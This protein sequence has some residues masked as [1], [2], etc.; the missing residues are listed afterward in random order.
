MNE[1]RQTIARRDAGAPVLAEGEEEVL[2]LAPAASGSAALGPLAMVLALLLAVTA[3]VAGI[4]SYLR[5]M[6]RRRRERRESTA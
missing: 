5:A 2:D 1:T 4:V 6:A 3:V